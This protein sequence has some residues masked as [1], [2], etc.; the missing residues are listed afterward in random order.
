MQ[1][2]L[3]FEKEMKEQLD[4]QEEYLRRNILKE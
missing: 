3:V 1:E 2:V 4:K